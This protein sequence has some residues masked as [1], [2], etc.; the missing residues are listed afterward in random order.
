MTPP[1]LYPSGTS[2]DT[3]PKSFG[4]RG[5]GARGGASATHVAETAEGGMTPPRLGAPPPKGGEA[6]ATHVDETAEGGMTP[7]RLWERKTLA[8]T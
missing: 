1:S 3:S 8:R 6:S 5:G 4:F 2:R 7:P